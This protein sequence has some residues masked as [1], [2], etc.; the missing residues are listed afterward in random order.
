ML[1]K[2]SHKA[3]VLFLFF[4]G[5]IM[6][7]FKKKLPQRFKKKK[8]YTFSYPRHKVR[9][10][11]NFNVDQ[12]CFHSSKFMKGILSGRFSVNMTLVV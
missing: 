1:S 4:T 3:A 9:R 12:A 5:I 8:K 7:F 2:E 6:Y 10:H 11:F